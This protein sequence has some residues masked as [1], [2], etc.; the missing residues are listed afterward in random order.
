MS[1]LP[2]CPKCKSDLTYQDGQMYV[3]PECAHEWAPASAQAAAPER[4]RVCRE[5]LAVGLLGNT[6]FPQLGRVRVCG[7]HVGSVGR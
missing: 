4:V 6:Y 3:C 1:S 5:G 2:A 7:D